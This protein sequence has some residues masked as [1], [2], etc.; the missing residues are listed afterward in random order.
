MSATLRDRTVLVIGR[1]SGIARATALAVLAA[2]GTVVAAGRDAAALG[3][4]YDDPGIITE[5]VDL[6][7]ES[8][9]EALAERLGRVDHVVST[10]SARARGEVGDLKQDTVLQL[11]TSGLRK[12]SHH[13]VI[14]VGQCGDAEERPVAGED[15][16]HRSVEERGRGPTNGAAAQHRRRR[17]G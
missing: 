10:A 2:G 16:L 6:T 12:D 17:A 3:G 13:G 7:D 1:G 8:S 9:V 15:C 14:A 4:A 11:R 5:S